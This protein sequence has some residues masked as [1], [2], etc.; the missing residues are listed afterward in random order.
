MKLVKHVPY[1]MIFLILMPKLEFL[2]HFHGPLNIEN[3]SVDGAS[4]YL[5]HILVFFFFLY[6]WR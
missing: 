1:D 3:D 4:V 2:S 6:L 5:E